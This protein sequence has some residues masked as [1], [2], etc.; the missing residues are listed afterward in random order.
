MES[1]TS[2]DVVAGEE[3]LLVPGVE[4]HL[5]DTLPDALETELHRLQG[6]AGYIHTDKI[7][8]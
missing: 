3:L 1:T 7:I 2:S 8:Y 4:S 6:T 5:S